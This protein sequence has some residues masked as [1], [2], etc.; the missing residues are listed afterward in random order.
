[1][2]KPTLEETEKAL[3]R[4]IKGREREGGKLNKILFC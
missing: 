3:V 4:F 1:L 2:E